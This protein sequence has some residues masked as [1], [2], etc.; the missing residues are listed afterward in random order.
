MKLSPENEIEIFSMDTEQL[1]E[2]FKTL[3]F[4]EPEMLDNAMQ[5]VKYGK[6]L[7]FDIR[8]VI[9]DNIKEDTKNRKAYM[10]T[11]WE[12]P[13]DQYWDELD[14]RT[15]MMRSLAVKYVQEQDLFTADDS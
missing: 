1:W 10:K 13:L 7:K 11:G 2:L 9:K 5:T 6:T 3:H 4:D 12:A 15:A 14:Q 8:D